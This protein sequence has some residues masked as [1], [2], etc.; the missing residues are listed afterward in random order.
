MRIAL[1][2]LIIIHALIHLFG[3][4]K[5]FGFVQFNEISVP[6]S[7]LFGTI[8]LLASIL[9]TIAFFLLI[10]QS[11]YWW[12]IAFLGILISQFLIFNYW[13][14]AKVGS[15]LNLIILIALLVA[16]SKD[17]FI[18]KVA[19]ERTIMFEKIDTVQEKILSQTMIEDLPLPL[20]KWI[21]TNGAV[22]KQMVNNVYLEQDLLLLM[23]PGQ[24][25][26]NKG[27]AKQI[28]T[29]SPPAFNW[30]I[31]MKLNRLLP[32]VGR[33]KFVD[34]QG[35]MNIKMFSLL[36]LANAKNNSKIDQASMQRYLAEIVWF[37][38]AVLSP[39]ISWKTLDAY[40]VQA[41]ME[42]N[43][44]IASGVFYFNENGSFQKFVALRYKGVDDKQ[45]L[46]W[47]VTALRI[48]ERNGIKI[49]I[50]CEA[51]WKLANGDWTWLKLKITNI[52]YNINTT[53][54]LQNYL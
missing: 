42:Y 49:P 3:F 14:D 8:W 13:S 51:T 10:I 5:A 36:P 31:S 29:T 22:G 12:L 26:W 2:I 7:K 35:E 15:V 34:G 44:T 40:S 39:Y 23:K 53:K 41:T 52:I 33:D 46:Q 37:P 30:D 19:D 24:K 6:I 45:A 17:R 9:L 28:F 38:S 27:K 11:N 16:F 54:N 25:E 47:T 1:I 21:L 18:K 50:E 32:V 43:G 4:L 48:E 20:Q